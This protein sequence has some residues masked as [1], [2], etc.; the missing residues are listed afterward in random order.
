RRETLH[1]AFV[2]SLVNIFERHL[3]MSNPSRRNLIY[4][5]VP[6]SATGADLAAFLCKRYWD[7]SPRPLRSLDAIQLASAMLAAT[8]SGEEILFVTADTRLAEIAALEGFSVVN[9][10]SPP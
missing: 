3:A 1:P 8:A 5:I 6:L 4:R 7:V 2:D 10:V 9:P